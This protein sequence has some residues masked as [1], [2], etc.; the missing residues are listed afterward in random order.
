M[1]P[2]IL[3]RI[4]GGNRW[5]TESEVEEEEGASVRAREL[6]EEGEESEEE[7]EDDIVEGDAVDGSLRRRSDLHLLIILKALSS[8]ARQS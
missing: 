8:L 7:S 5:K 1:D 6:D 3:S 2:M 4:S